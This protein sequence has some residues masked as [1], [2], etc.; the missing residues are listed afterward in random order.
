MD[1]E[2]SEI[3]QQFFKI[4]VVKVRNLKPRVLQT[5]LRF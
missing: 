4:Y 1:Q 3:Y 5:K 2:L